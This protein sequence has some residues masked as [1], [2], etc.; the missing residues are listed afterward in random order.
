MVRGHQQHVIQSHILA[1]AEGLA[2]QEQ[3]QGKQI[4]VVAVE[5]LPCKDVPP[6]LLPVITLITGLVRVLPRQLITPHVIVRIKDHDSLRPSLGLFFSKW[7]DLS[8]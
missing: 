7:E 4:V 6:V 1:K 5:A 2:V 8:F 3:V